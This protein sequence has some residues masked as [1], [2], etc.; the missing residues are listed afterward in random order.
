[1]SIISSKPLFT[2]EVVKSEFM[3]RNSCR[4]SFSY[5]YFRVLLHMVDMSN[6]TYN[7]GGVGPVYHSIAP[8]NAPSFKWVIVTQSL[9]LCVVICT[10]K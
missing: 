8:E 10:E 6:T 2:I 3:L 5:A 7:S 4:R 1:M 9:V